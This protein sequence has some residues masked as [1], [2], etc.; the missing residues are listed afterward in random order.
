[1]SNHFGVTSSPTKKLNNR[2]PIEANDEIP[3]RAKVHLQGSG[4]NDAADGLAQAGEAEG[5]QEAGG[6]ALDLDEKSRGAVLAEDT[7]QLGGVGTEGGSLLDE[8]TGDGDLADDGT[9]RGG[10]AGGAAA[11]EGAQ[12][13]VTEKAEDGGLNLDED[14]V[15]VLTGDAHDVGEG[16][17]LQVGKAAEVA[18]VAT[19]SLQSADEA[20]DDLGNATEGGQKG[21]K[22]V[23]NLGSELDKGVLALGGGNGQDTGGQAVGVQLAGRAGEV[24]DL[25][26]GLGDAA[27]V[28]TGELLS[29]ALL[30][31]DEHLLASVGD[32]EDTVDGVAG[33]VACSVAGELAGERAETA[34][35]GGGSGRGSGSRGAVGDVRSKASRSRRGGNAAEGAG[36][37]GQSSDG[38]CQDGGDGEGLHLG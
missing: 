21:R 30:K 16:V 4:G 1:M 27:E 9:E 3:S 12:G 26:N 7:D 15:A 22:E 28:Q 20:T 6:S 34:G 19:K 11:E 23:L 14:V 38:G 25:T 33:S 37:S 35:T 5:G 8:V 31:L 17:A 36:A 2:G 32:G 18:Q 24:G 29:E 10:L 13:Q